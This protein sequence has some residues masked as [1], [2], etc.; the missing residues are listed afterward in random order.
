M[1][2]S[3]RRPG[4]RVRRRRG[5]RAALALDMEVIAYDPFVEQGPDVPLVGLD[6]LL[7]RADFVSLHVPLTA[8]TANMIGARELELM[9]ESAYLV[10]CA[11][12]RVV[13]EGALYEACK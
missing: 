7:R 10:N 11:R 9:K 1:T 2:L 3:F 13:D 6:D 8:L 12:G 5:G 4:P